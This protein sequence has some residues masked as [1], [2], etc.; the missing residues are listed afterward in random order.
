MT[1]AIF[2]GDALG[3]DFL[4][5]VATPLDT[6]VDWIADGE[7][8][9]DWVEQARLAPS[10]ALASIRKQALPGELDRTADQA[11]RLREWF[12]GFVREHMGRRLAAED[13]AELEPLNRLLERDEVFTRITRAAKG[14]DMPFELEAARKWRTPEALL[15]P[16][17]EA[18][19][20]FVCSEDFSHVKACEGP[21]CTLLF[22]DHTRGH[23]RRWCSMA[24]CGNRAKQ[25]AH[26][27]RIKAHHD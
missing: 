8:L 6:P 1:S 15:P 22:A 3:L 25:A 11:R 26:R 27:H 19:A 14:T 4:N 12:R 18:L 7:G 24:Q 21:A 23:R 13:F 2:V 9:L 20:R 17:G 5:S 16:I 10:E